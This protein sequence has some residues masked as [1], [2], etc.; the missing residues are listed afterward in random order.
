MAFVPSDDTYEIELAIRAF[1]EAGKVPFKKRQC[2]I[3]LEVRSAGTHRAS[4]TRT[5][6][7]TADTSELQASTDKASHPFTSNHTSSYGIAV[8]GEVLRPFLGPEV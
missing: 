3:Y 6:G 7:T 8:D 2:Y 1:Y 4:N 5:I